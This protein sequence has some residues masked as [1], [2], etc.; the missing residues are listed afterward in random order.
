MTSIA[1]DLAVGG[2]TVPRVKSGPFQLHDCYSGDNIAQFETL[3][4]TVA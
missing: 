4:F 3:F 2:A 1:V